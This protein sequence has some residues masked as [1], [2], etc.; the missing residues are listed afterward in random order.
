MQ[1]LEADEVMPARDTVVIDAKDTEEMSCGFIVLDH[2]SD[3]LKLRAAI[4][5]FIKLNNIQPLNT[6]DNGK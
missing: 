2:P 5:G 3:L 4:D 6:C 1:R